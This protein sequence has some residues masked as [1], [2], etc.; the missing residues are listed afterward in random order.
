MDEATRI[1]KVAKALLQGSGLTQEG[2]RGGLALMC[3]TNTGC[4]EGCMQRCA[5]TGSAK[6]AVAWNLCG[7]RVRRATLRS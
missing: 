3:G 4:G 1:A 2:V 5:Q 6:A 7:R